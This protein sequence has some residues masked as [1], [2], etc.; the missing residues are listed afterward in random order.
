M[1]KIAAPGHHELTFDEYFSDICVGHS[2]SSSGLK[3][4]EQKSLA[5]Y[6]HESFL[7]PNRVHKDTKAM[8]FG[9]ACHAWTLGDPVFNEA[10][11][12]SPYD[13]FRSKEARQWKET[14]SRTVITAA[15]FEAIQAMSKTIQAHPLLRNAFTDGK[16]EQSLV[17]VDKETGIWLKTRPDWLPNALH[18]V[19]DFKT[20][21]NGR[22]DAFARQAFN[23]GYHMSAALC[24]EGLR[25]VLGWSDAM[26]YFVVQEKEPPYVAT[27]ILMRD[28]DVEWGALQNRSALRKLARALDSGKWPG[29]ADAVVEIDMPGHMEHGLQARHE[30]GEFQTPEEKEAA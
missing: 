20:T 15:Q 23:L 1:K 16:P 13:D 2:V 5:H 4:I 27:P 30:R 28:T 11:V 19:P 6:W 14:Q 12:I 7:N 22:P 10:H 3:I 26:Y 21:V 8:S 25:T 29:Y 18:M 24:I 9:R 17:W